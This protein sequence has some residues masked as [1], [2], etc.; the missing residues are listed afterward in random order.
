VY[1][2]VRDP[3][4]PK[5]ENGQPGTKWVGPVPAAVPVGID[6]VGRPFAEPTLLKIASAY[7]AA[8]KHRKP[9]PGFGPLPDEP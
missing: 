6:F 3:Q 9:P 7:E 5:G 8:T 2:S 1:D 4:A